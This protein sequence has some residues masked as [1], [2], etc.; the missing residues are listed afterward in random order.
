MG[1]NKQTGRQASNKTL[2]CR[3]GSKHVS[4]FPRQVRT[5]ATV[6]APHL[7][8][9]APP[10]VDSPTSAT[11]AV[12]APPHR[13]RTNSLNSPRCVCLRYCTVPWKPS[14]SL[15]RPTKQPVVVVVVVVLLPPWVC[16]PTFCIS[17]P[18]PAATQPSIGLPRGWPLRRRNRRPTT[19]MQRA[20]RTPLTTLSS[21]PAVV[22]APWTRRTPHQLA[23][24]RWPPGREAHGP[25]S[26]TEPP[27]ATFGGGDCTYHPIYEVH[28]TSWQPP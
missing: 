17:P 19:C 11:D 7:D 12:V 15:G 13:C 2:R 20:I 3:F 22:V 6:T 1:T 23:A 16:R 10:C 21:W 27:A 9:V 26:P 18:L 24:D 8:S 5:P 28:V 25:L 4:T 14:N